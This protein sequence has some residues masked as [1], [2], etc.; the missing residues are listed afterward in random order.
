MIWEGHW[1]ADE[2]QRERRL[3]DGMGG[4]HHW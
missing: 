2:A 3:T 1:S 4:G